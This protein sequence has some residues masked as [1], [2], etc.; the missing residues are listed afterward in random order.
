MQCPV[1][2]DTQ[3]VMSERKSIEI[4]YCPNCRG[5]WLD[6]GELDKIIEKSVES[7][8]APAAA[9][10]YADNRERDRDRDHHGYSKSKPY[11][12]RSFLSDLFD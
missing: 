5:V 8:P 7:T 10:P 3:L 11:K 2:K 4:D 12:K 1:C 9:A 6:R